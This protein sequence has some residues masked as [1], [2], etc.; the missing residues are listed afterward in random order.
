MLRLWVK[1]ILVFLKEFMISNWLM[2]KAVVTNHEFEGGFI[3]F[4]LNVKN[5]KS[6]AFLSQMI[7]LTPGTTTV[8]YDESTNR[9]L[10]YSFYGKDPNGVIMSI[11]KNFETILKEI[12]G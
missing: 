8:S 2:V 3:E 10:I 7:T 4:T 12:W 5:A 11:R 6:I 9:L 1:L